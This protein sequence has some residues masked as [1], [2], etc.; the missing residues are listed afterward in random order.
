M[1]NGGRMR[2][3]VGCTLKAPE[4]EAIERGEDL[5]TRVADKLTSVPLAPPDPA[6]TNALELVAWMVARGHLDVKVAVPCDDDGLPVPDD[7][8]FH[9][10]SGIIQ[11]PRRRP[12][13]L[14]RQH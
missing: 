12:H 11:D 6:T 13:R 7:A 4:I 9:E 10:K 8:I 3:V 5:R 1:H 14:D 2:L